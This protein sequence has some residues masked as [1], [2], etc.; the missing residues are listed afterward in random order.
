MRVLCLVGRGKRSIRENRTGGISISYF[1]LW[2]SLIILIPE[3]LLADCPRVC[4]LMWF[5]L[6]SPVLWIKP[7]LLY[8]QEWDTEQVKSCSSVCPHKDFD[9]KGEEFKLVKIS[10][11]LQKIVKFIILLGT[12]GPDDFKGLFQHKWFYDSG[13]V[14]A[15]FFTVVFIRLPCSL[16]CRLSNTFL[17]LAVYKPN[18]AMQQHPAA[19]SAVLKGVCCLP[20]TTARHSKAENWQFLTGFGLCLEAEVDRP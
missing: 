4:M 6:A 2:N 1:A 16:A 20:L 17:A 5:K 13:R 8:C 12:M 10:T 11:G 18:C 14:W 19:L 9:L 7:L 15:V 3:F